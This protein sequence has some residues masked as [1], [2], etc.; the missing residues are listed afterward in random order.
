MYIQ[1]GYCPLCGSPIYQPEKWAGTCPPSLYYV[2]NCEALIMKHN[3][4]QQNVS[5]YHNFKEVVNG[6]AIMY[7]KWE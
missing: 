4:N 6:H 7:Q 3:P 2:C 5:G 1:I